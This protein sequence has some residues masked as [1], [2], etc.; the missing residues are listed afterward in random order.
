MWEAVKIAK[1]QNID[2][3]PDQMKHNGTFVSNEN[4]AE[5]FAT[6]FEK[7]IQ[8]IVAETTIDNSVY[9]GVR[10]VTVED[11]NF[12]TGFNIRNSKM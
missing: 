4:L 5:E 6:M 7:K 3:L 2:D 11:K 8:D 9:N 10:K 12:M 1:D